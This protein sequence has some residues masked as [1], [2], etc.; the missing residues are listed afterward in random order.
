MSNDLLRLLV[1]AAVACVAYHVLFKDGGLVKNDGEVSAQPYE[2]A[3]AVQVAQ[4]AEHVMPFD[5]EAEVSAAAPA[6]QAQEP[7]AA[8]VDAN[9][10]KRVENAQLD[11]IHQNN[12]D[13]LPPPQLSNNF[14]PLAGQA[15][16]NDP[17]FNHLNCFPQDAVKPGELLPSDN[18]GFSE[19]NPRG[20]GQLSNRNLFESAHHAGL[21]TQGSSLRNG[22]RQIR[23]DPL[24]PRVDVGPWHQS[25]YEA[26]T[27]RR[28][29]EI[30][31]I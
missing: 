10:Y 6:A 7:E 3:Q 14:A 5:A 25:T 4:E 18:N 17:K 12:T 27:N 24:I 13:V 8:T 1:I 26:D 16:V 11:G 31:G 20:Q 9:K 21:N 23:S 19:S 29:F 28:T 15:P 30:G 22:N 2:D